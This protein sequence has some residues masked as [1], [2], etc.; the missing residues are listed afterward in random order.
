M[1]Q[2]KIK[3]VLMAE[4]KEKLLKKG[5]SIAS[6]AREQGYEETYVIKY[7]HRYTA[8]PQ[9]PRSPDVFAIL[10]A[11][12]RDTGINLMKKVF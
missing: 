9:L 7:L 6:W 11:I 8:K 3:T 5:Y 10:N 12:R 2:A 4:I 1:A